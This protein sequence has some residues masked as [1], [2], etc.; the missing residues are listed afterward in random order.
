[1]TVIRS[2]RAATGWSSRA[3]LTD[4]LQDPDAPRYFGKTKK[5]HDMKP[6]RLPDDELRALEIGRAHV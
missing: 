1:M 6:L 2:S 3:W 4:F 5:L